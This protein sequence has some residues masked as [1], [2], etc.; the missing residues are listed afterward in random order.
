MFKRMKIN[1][2]LT[3]SF[4]LVAGITSIAAIVGCFAMLYVSDQYTYAL[5]NY[6]FSQGDIGKALVTYADSRSATR[7]II[8]Y[9]DSKVIEEAVSTHDQKK[10]SFEQYMSD[11]SKTL[12]APEE[13]ATYDEAQKNLTEYWKID[14]QVI[15]MGNTTD[16]AQSKAAQA[17]AAEQLDPLYEKVY[18]SMSDLMSLN[19]E[20]GNELDASLGV[21]STVLLLVIVGVI[22]ASIVIAI[23][24]GKNIANGIARPMGDLSKRL[25]GFA[26]GDLSSEFP[27]V[28]SEDEVADMVK[29]AGEMAANLSAII[30]DAG[31]LMGLM[32][33]GN[34]SQTSRIPERYVGEFK[35]LVDAMTQMNAQMNETLRQIES[36]SDQVSAGAGNLAESSQSLAE[37]ATEQAGAIEELQATIT[38]LTEGVQ[39]TA[40][41]VDES[42]RQANKYANEAEQSKAEMQQMVEAMERINETSNKIGNIISDIE[43][44]ATQTNLLSL[45][46]SIE[47]ARAGEAGRGF[48]VVADQIRKLAEQ[49]AASVVDTRELIEN[50]IQVVASGNQ[51]AEKV[52]SSI[53]EVVSGVNRIAETSKEL[54]EISLAQA[55][56]MK[57]AEEG[58]NQISEVVQSNS[59]NAEESS[60]T[61][62]E[63]SAQS[64]TLNELVQKFTLK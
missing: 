9:T 40:E 28:S 19:V 46:A 41:S 2:R 45:N 8:G 32:A 21:L 33:D 31:E 11:I 61:S 53:G 42:Y 5:K 1:K 43:D 12:T 15:E 57:Q 37:G 20:T 35:A 10:Q 26:G 39:K 59:A 62:E 51:M 27:A 7:A 16:E 17:L 34:Y 56:A 29:V 3:I 50:S 49:S 25:I 47:A 60:A 36:A 24:L 30:K 18:S 13:K 58:V 23:L 64:E 22:V 38:N 14:A 4:I 54:R 52:A 48:A 63:L 55:E 6:G 44:I